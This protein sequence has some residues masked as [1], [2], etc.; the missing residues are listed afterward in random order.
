MNQA[1]EVW[2]MSSISRRTVFRGAA[3]AAGLAAFSHVSGLRS[4]RAQGAAYEIVS[5]GPVTDGVMAEGDFRS[6]PGSMNDIHA[7]G[8][9]FGRLAASAEKFFPVL[10]NADG[11]LTK[12]KSGT[13]GGFV[14]G[15]N[16]SGV[17]VGEVYE[18]PDGRLT[19]E[20][21]GKRPAAWIDGELV[22]LDLPGDRKY[23]FSRLGGR[24]SSVSD[25]GVIFGSANGYDVLWVDG[26]V[27][28]LEPQQGD[29]FLGSFIT[30]MPDGRLMAERDEWYTNDDGSR[31]SRGVI[32]VFD[33]GSFQDLP[34]G[35]LD[36]GK[37]GTPSFVGINDAG[38][39]LFSFQPTDF[40]FTLVTGLDVVP[41]VLDPRETGVL[42]RPSGFNAANE[43]VGAMSTRQDLDFE[44][45]IWRDGT[46]TPL[47]ELLPG[48][49]GFHN[50]SVFGIS[51]DGIIAGHGWDADGGFHPLLFVPA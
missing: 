33:S 42:F 3:G 31:S 50:L 37:R 12:L 11:S 8:T 2:E 9:A 30:V 10:F 44:P 17:A 14:A 34:T 41:I 24:A 23:D 19:A 5:F 21:E 38:H 47:A 13:F 22:R 46:F 27:Q 36:L 1:R 45:A 51:N 29:L 28:V 26:V 6:N 16:A 4:I 49:N 20:D 48:E 15:M 35:S 25:N 32:G 7:N 39:G 40:A 43:I 18:T